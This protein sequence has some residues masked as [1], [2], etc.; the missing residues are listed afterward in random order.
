M[1]YNTTGG[2]VFASPVLSND[3][4]RVYLGSDDYNMTVSPGGAV[5]SCEWWILQLLHSTVSNDDDVGI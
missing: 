5:S 4:T 3:G 1:G 2:D